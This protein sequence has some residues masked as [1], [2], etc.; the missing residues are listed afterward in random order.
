MASVQDQACNNKP[1]SL[2]ML[3]RTIVLSFSRKGFVMSG[4]RR[5][6]GFGRFVDTLGSAIAVAS[7][8]ES[9]R[10]PLARDLEALG[11]DPRQ[12]T[13]IRHR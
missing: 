10:R 8:V 1:E 3:Q 7:A 2:F 6:S 12:F 9:G 4:N 5:F 13:K 11:I